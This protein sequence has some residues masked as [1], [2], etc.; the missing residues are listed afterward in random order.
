MMKRSASAGSMRTGKLVRRALPSALTAAA[1]LGGTVDQGFAQS[2]R[3]WFGSKPAPMAP[4]PASSQNGF[5]ATIERLLVDARRQ[6][7]AG[8]V[9]EAI[10]TA[11]RA[12]K[13]A[14]ASSAV[15]HDHPEV[16]TAAADQLL[17]ELLAMRGTSAQ[18]VV[19]AAPSSVGPAAFA[20][21][22]APSQV[23]PPVVPR[24]AIPERR[25]VTPAAEEFVPTRDVLASSRSFSAGS[26]DR[27][28]F[29]I[30]GGEAGTT[31][32]AES[33]S[34]PID[35]P[36]PTI[37]V[38]L[39]PGKP[40][41][42]VS[43]T[44]RPQPVIVR[45]VR[46]VPVDE[47]T[48]WESTADAGP[49][50]PVVI[51]GRGLTF[52]TA[53]ASVEPSPEVIVRAN[54]AGSFTISEPAAELLIAPAAEP[55]GFDNPP[56]AP[57]EPVPLASPP[58]E[59]NSTAPDRATRAAAEVDSAWEST[60]PQPASEPAA[61]VMPNAGAMVRLAHASEVDR[62][63]PAGFTAVAP[64]PPQEPVAA[65]ALDLA[66]IEHCSEPVTVVR[67]SGAMAI[68]AAAKPQWSGSLID[69]LAR[70]WQLPAQTVAA[71]LA[72]AG[73]LL[74]G[75]GLTLVRLATRRS[76]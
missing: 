58:T 65:P 9:E 16:S 35:A 73:L 20:V 46:S 34:E 64:P 40:M 25:A 57:S 48:A 15:L 23:R 8:Q 37:E 10:K 43:E 11:Q 7:A 24:T 66:A 63:T 18:T 28:G 54:H 75:V 17:R 51:L 19:A 39:G 69:Q 13:I 42:S 2:G 76:A 70:Q 36:F 41:P 33:E 55:I 56:L 45:A 21:R 1:I 61:T 59:W 30:V 38:V 27:K 67:E 53:T 4:Q 74:L 32:T 62:V 26:F 60:T 71:G 50:E 31:R 3:K 6:A 52:P 44:P 49:V 14:E 29:Q 68:P 22:P 47:S 72:A 5:A 12:R